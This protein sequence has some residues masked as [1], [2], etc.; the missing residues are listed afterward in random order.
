MVGY[1][2]MSEMSK[3]LT[4]GGD[5]L[6]VPSHWVR[7]FAHLVPAGTT[8]LDLAAGA[9]RHARFFRDRGNWVTAVDRTVAGMANLAGQDRIEIIEADLENGSP[10]PLTGRQFGGIVVTNYLHRQ[11]LPVLAA[12]LAPRGVLIY[13]T[14][15]EGQQ[16]FGRPSNPNFMLKPGEL[17]QVFGATLTVVAYEYGI[18]YTPHPSAIQRIAAVNGA[19]L[20]PL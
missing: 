14:F 10:W 19:G 15:A 1:D 17:L 11:L 9:G 6:G 20:N 7:R 13:E 3:G 4:Q 5:P 8:V 16:D 12:S 2:A 18:H